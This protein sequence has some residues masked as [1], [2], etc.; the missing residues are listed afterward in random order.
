MRNK[1]PQVY[2]HKLTVPD[3]ALDVNGHVNNIE[4]IRWMQDAAVLHSDIQGCTKATI[5]AGAT[6]VVRT[7]RI[8][9]LRPAFAGEQIVVL[10]WVTNFRRVQSLRK[11]KIVRLDDNTVLVEGETNWV[12][13]D[14]KTGTLRSIPPSVMATFEILPK[15]R[16]SEI[17]SLLNNSS[18]EKICD[19]ENQ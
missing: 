8:E 9:Y 14:A 6:W 13:V 4:Y 2:Q 5:E 11:Y 10:T 15:E 1:M 3:H 17:I 7:H 12:F 19:K 18:S 16:E